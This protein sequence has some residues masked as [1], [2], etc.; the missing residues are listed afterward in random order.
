MA[1]ELPALKR[2]D[3]VEL[4]VNDQNLLVDVHLVG[5]SATTVSPRANSSNH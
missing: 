2:G 4:T 3:R 5:E 1:K